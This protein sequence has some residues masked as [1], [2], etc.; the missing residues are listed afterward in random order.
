MKQSVRRYCDEG[1]DIQSAADKNY[2]REAVRERPVQVVTAA[3]C[4]VN[5]KQKSIDVTKIPNFSAY[6]NFQFEPQGIRVRKAYSVGQGKFVNYTNIVRTPQ[7]A[8][9]L[10]VKN[11]QNFFYMPVKRSLKKQTVNSVESFG[12]VPVSTGRMWLIVP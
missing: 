3:V 9:S 11:K 4:E 12:I 1:N 2:M 8:T 10:T 6:H 7:G 5:D